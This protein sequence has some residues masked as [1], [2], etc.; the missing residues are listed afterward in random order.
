VTDSSNLDLVR[1]IYADW[2]R[3]D[4]SSTGWMHPDIEMVWM[5]WLTPRTTK[6]VGEG[7]A[8][9]RD[10]LGTL[11]AA[12]T[13]IEEIREIDHER[14]LVLGHY[15]GRAKASGL[16]IEKISRVAALAH[17]EGGLVTKLVLYTDRNRALADLGLEG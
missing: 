11:E 13:V 14:V 2:E 5:D 6:G 12:S 15:R 4:Y 3:G 7:W 9:F 1:S 10:W 8:V 16:D 17:V